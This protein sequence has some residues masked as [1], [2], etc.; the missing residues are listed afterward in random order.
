MPNIRLEFLLPYS[1]DFN[2]IELVWHSAKEYI[3]PR[4]FEFVNQLEELLNKLL[5]EGQL[6][7]NSSRRIKNKGNA[8]Y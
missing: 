7:I 5:N 1:P 8:I 3:A 2:L 6:I 4:L